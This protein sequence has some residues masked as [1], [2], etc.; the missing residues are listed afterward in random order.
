M[1]AAIMVF[2]TK[3]N[4]NATLV[5]QMLIAVYNTALKTV[6]DTDNV[7]I[8]LVVYANLDLKVLV[9]KRNNAQ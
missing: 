5:T 6:M 4:V 8:T 7:L 1:N 3:E 9:A 2:A